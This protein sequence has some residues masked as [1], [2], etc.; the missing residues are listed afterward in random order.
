MTGGLDVGTN[1][2]CMAQ[3]AERN[4]D[5]QNARRLYDAAATLGIFPDTPERLD[6]GTVLWS[7][8]DEAEDGERY[9]DAERLFLEAAQ[10]GNIL[11]MNRLARLYDDV[12][13]PALPDRAIYWYVRAFRAGEDNAAWDLAMH[14][15]PRANHRWYR[16][17][18]RKAAESGHSDAVEELTRIKADPAYM[19]KLP[20]SDEEYER[21]V[22]S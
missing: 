5:E 6:R 7:L 12:F 3:K 13:Q 22:T 11:S 8:A 15:V 9:D 17:W 21:W 18:I 1:Y 4:D 14:Y 19:I 10:L 20:L 16:F 2:F